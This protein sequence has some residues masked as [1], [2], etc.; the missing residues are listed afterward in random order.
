[1]SFYITEIDYCSKYDI[2]LVSCFVMTIK[3]TRLLNNQ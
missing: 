1:M 3:N 2:E